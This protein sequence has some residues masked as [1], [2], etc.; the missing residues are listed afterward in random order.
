MKQRPEREVEDATHNVSYDDDVTYLNVDGV[1]LPKASFQLANGVIGMS[2]K[3]V[4]IAHTL[5][6]E[7]GPG[8]AAME[9]ADRHV[10]TFCLDPGSCMSQT[11]TFPLR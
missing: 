9:P 11:S 2:V 7:K 10:T 3:D 1:T 5:L 4:E 6:V 8:D